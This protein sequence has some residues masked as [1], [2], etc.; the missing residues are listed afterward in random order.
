MIA[1]AASIVGIYP[2]VSIASAKH[3]SPIN[4]SIFG[5]SRG[6][7]I[8]ISIDLFYAVGSGHLSQKTN[9]QRL[10]LNRFPN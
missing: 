2:N 9:E 8:V 7:L 1:R 4:S 6:F 5:K 10:P 3:S